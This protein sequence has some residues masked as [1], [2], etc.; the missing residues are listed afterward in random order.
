MEPCAPGTEDDLPIMYSTLN[1]QV[2]INFIY[3][4]FFDITTLS[5]T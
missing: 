3:I 2:H 1:K 5:I 4:K